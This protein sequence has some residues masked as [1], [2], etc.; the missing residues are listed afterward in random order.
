MTAPSQRTPRAARAVAVS[1]VLVCLTLVAH[2]SGGA[3]FPGWFAVAAFALLVWPAALVATR[4]RLRLP[5]LLGGL[6]LGQVLGHE[7]MTVLGA[8]GGAA[9][10]DTDCLTHAAHRVGTAGG[11][12][13]GVMGGGMPGMH[14]SLAMLVAHGAATLVAALVIARSEAVLW[15]LLDLVVPRF[16]GLPHCPSVLVPPAHTPVW[17]VHEAC[18]GTWSCRGPPLLPA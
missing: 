13:T 14:A 7:V 9:G 5:G 16:P 1:V 15:R 3:P 10:F 12:G 2:L 6:V 8:G 17:A 11:C 4:R 18:R